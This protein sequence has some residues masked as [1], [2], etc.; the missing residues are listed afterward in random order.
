MDRETLWGLV[1]VAYVLP[2]GLWQYS[3]YYAIEARKNVYGDR[4]EEVRR[5][6][7]FYIISLAWSAGLVALL[8]AWYAGWK[9][10]PTAI[11]VV[12]LFV[13]VAGISTVVRRW[14]PFANRHFRYWLA[15]SAVWGVAVLGWFLIFGRVSPL[16]DEEI[17]FL[18]AVPP[19]VGAFALAA[20]R[21]ARK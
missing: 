2:F 3:E 15:A 18:G 9:P 21:W 11:T 13:L 20:W 4:P 1:L 19:I 16:R 7:R 12:G 17:F 14:K 8:S 10:I 5:D 6:R